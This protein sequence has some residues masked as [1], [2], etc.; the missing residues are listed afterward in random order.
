MSG[1]DVRT[2]NGIALYLIPLD[3]VYCSASFLAETSVSSPQRYIHY[4]YLS[5]YFLDQSSQQIFNLNLKTEALVYCGSLASSLRLPSHAH[6]SRPVQTTLTHG[7]LVRRVAD[8]SRS[9][10]SLMC[11][12]TTYVQGIQVKKYGVQDIRFLCHRGVGLDPSW[13]FCNSC[14]PKVIRFPTNQDVRLNPKLHMLCMSS[15]TLQ[16]CK[17][18]SKE[19][20]LGMALSNTRGT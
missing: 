3:V 14:V 1:N 19:F 9:V 11:I 4:Y 13:I 18:V 2:L 17:R 6:S 12:S 10:K 20:S 16:P 8:S 15:L 7:L 5:K